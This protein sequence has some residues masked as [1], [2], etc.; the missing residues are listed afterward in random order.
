M[1]KQS[2]PLFL[3]VF[4]ILAALISA[5][6]L[7][8][9]SPAEVTIGLPAGPS[10]SSAGDFGVAEYR[11]KVLEGD[12]VLINKEFSTSESSLH[13]SLQAGEKNHFVL[14]ALDDQGAVA[15]SG[16]ATKTLQEGPNVI[17]IT[18]VAAGPAVE[19]PPADLA[20]GDVWGGGHVFY[21]FDSNDGPLYVDGEIHGFI[22]ADD[23]VDG[24]QT[25][26]SAYW[27]D[28]AHASES[29]G[30]TGTALGTGYANTLAIIDVSGTGSGT[31]YAAELAR[32]YEGGGYTD[33]FLPSKDELL[34]LYNNRNYTETTTYVNGEDYWSSSETNATQAEFLNNFSIAGGGGQD[35]TSKTGTKFVRP[36]R[37]F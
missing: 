9:P 3:T 21:I 8:A 11:L 6:N 7:L 18:L 10:R 25:A 35:Y 27:C 15:L 29:V 12:T 20:L 34:L 16:T 17:E 19:V 13:I 36:I 22:A 26:N 37:Q 33:W 14:D 32:G 30:T 1:K 28:A 31:P 23:D 2:I 24:P 5:C 4:A